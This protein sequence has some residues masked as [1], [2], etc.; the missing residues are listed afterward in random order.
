M[1][2]PATPLRSCAA[3]ASVFMPHTLPCTTRLGNGQS[4]IPDDCDAANPVANIWAYFD[5]G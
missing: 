1:H 4:E 3:V 2:G 5:A